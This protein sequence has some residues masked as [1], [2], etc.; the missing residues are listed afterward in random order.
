MKDKEKLKC[1]ECGKSFNS[2]KQIEQHK[3][4]VHHDRAIKPPRSFRL[5]KTVLAI[6]VGVVSIGILVAI[7]I[8][9]GQV[10]RGFLSQSQSPSPSPSTPLSV[11]NIQCNTME[12]S[13]FH[14]H[15]HLDIII[16]GKK[17]VIPAQIGIIPDKC[18]FWLHTHDESGIIHIESPINRYF[19]LGQFFNIWNKKFNN[20]Q[21]FNNVANANNT[22]NVYINGNKV[23]NGT[24]YRDIKLNAHDE[25]VIVYGKS[26]PPAI[27]SNYEFPQ[28]L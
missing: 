21:I 15:A 23:P 6:V 18:L 19:T 26:T 28:G 7:I 27:P 1:D 2:R 14:I 22:L 16:N 24:S 5:S 17:V 8:A 10:N 3:R 13:I 12:Q 11:D 20:N 4:D 9:A 25:I